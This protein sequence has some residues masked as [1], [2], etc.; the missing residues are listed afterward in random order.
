MAFMAHFVISPRC[1]EV[2]FS[3]KMSSYDVGLVIR[4]RI[5]SAA[6]KTTTKKTVQHSFKPV[7][8]LAFFYI[9]WVEVILFQRS[10]CL[11]LYLSL[12]IS[13]QFV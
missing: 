6:K 10:E 3:V 7:F 4:S 2:H 1:H 11:P 12:C 5:V 8:T 9:F 13:I